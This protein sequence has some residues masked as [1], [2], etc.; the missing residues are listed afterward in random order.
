MLHVGLTLAASQLFRGSNVM[1]SVRFGSNNLGKLQFLNKHHTFKP[2]H[3]ERDLAGQVCGGHL[4][5]PLV[6]RLLWLA[7]NVLDIAIITLCICRTFVVLL[8]MRGWCRFECHLVKQNFC[9]STMQHTASGTH[10]QLRKP[11]LSLIVI[12]FKGN[13]T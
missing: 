8:R 1:G 12:A 4:G 2:F 13:R 3:E 9:R 5:F 6:T 11:Q 7:I 10:D